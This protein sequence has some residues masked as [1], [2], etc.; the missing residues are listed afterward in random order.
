MFPVSEPIT[1]GYK[2]DDEGEVEVCHRI[3]IFLAFVAANISVS[4]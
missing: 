3:F 4:F 2:A 1:C